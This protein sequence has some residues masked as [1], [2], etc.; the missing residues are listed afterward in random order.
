MMRNRMALPSAPASTCRE[1]A[2]T[3]EGGAHPEKQ[4]ASRH[5]EAKRAMLCDGVEGLLAEEIHDHASDPSNGNFAHPID[6]DVGGED[7][8]VRLRGENDCDEAEHRD[9]SCPGGEGD[10]S[11]PAGGGK[12]FG[13]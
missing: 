8:K 10:L 9:H 1:G 7:E 6:G 2:E 5:G 3:D 4:S 13:N 11:R 12:P